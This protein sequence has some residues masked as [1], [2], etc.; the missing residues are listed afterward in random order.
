METYHSS[1]Q[2]MAMRLISWESACVTGSNAGGYTVSSVSYWAG[3]PTS[4]SVDLGVYADSS[5]TPGA[6]LCHASTGTITPTAGW[7]SVNISGCPTLSAGTRYWM[8]YIT[9][10]NQIQQ[11]TTPG[12]CPGTALSNVWANA[13]P[14]SAALSSPFGASSPSTNWCYSLY[15]TLNPVAVS[16]ACGETTQS[17]LDWQ[18]ARLGVATPCVTGT[19][20]GGYTVS[21]LSYCRPVRLPLTSFDLGVYSD[22]SGSPGSL[23]CH[24]STGTITPAAGWNSISISSC[25]TLSAST[26]YWV[27][28]VDGSDQI[29]QGTV[30]GTCTGTSN[31]TVFSNGVLP[32]VSLAN[33]FG[34]DSA[35]S[36][37]YSLYMTL[38]TGNQSSP[39]L[40]VSSSVNP[41]SYGQPVSLTATISSGPTGLVTFYSDGTQIGQALI[42]GTTATL[43]TTGLPLGSHSITA[44]WPGNANYQSVS[45]SPI[46][47][48]INVDTP[49][50]TWPTPAPLAYGLPLSATQLNATAN[51]PG[52]FVYTPAS[53]TVLSPGSHTLSVT[54][55]PTDTTDYTTA[56]DTVTLNVP[57]AP[58]AGIITTVAGDGGYGSSGDGGLAV[59][60]EL[61]SPEQIA[62][63]TTGNIKLP[64]SYVGVVRKVVASTGIIT[65]IAGTG[66][67]GYSGDGGQATSAQ[68]NTPMAIALDAAGNVYV[69]DSQS[70]RIRKITVSTGVITTIAGTG[71]AGYS[72]D[73]G[74]STSAQINYPLGVTFD[75]AGNL[76]IADTQNN[77][78]REVAASTGI[79]TTVAGNS[80][81]G[82]SGDGGP[83]TSA[84]LWG[85][86]SIAFDSSGN[87]YIADSYNQVIREVNHSSG[88][89]STIAGNRTAG[90]TGDNGPATSAELNYP[91][92]IS[93]DATGNV[94]ISDYANFVIRMVSPTGIITTV[95][96][97]GTSGFSGDGGPATS[98]QLSYPHGVALDSAGNLYIGDCG[99]HRVRVIGGASQAQVSVSIVPASATLYA[100][101]TKQFTATVT[102]TNNTAVTW[103]ITPAGSGSINSSGL[104]TA[105][106]TITTQQSVAVTATSQ[107][108][109]AVSSSA[110]VTLM[111]TI[112]VSISPSA[113]TL[114]W[115][116]IAAVLRNGNEHQQH[117]CDL[118]D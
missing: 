34:A 112:A 27:G 42:S 78:V 106:A 53:G 99:N 26:Q 90:Y 101:Q 114:L 9:G 38:S 60:A 97:N 59:N 16:N 32:G 2:M 62:V 66:T 103:S 115:R 75:S 8:G 79:I 76:Y 108:N 110:T 47:Q 96:G 55:T 68:L 69:A 83:A 37:C 28:Y 23:L 111:P 98:A 87:L 74:P 5:G 100:Q 91:Y 54:F 73:G 70:N 116:T 25:P 36:S 40:T 71:T 105:P 15:M 19:N 57:I 94:Y 41:A 86:E 10:S 33:P 80:F 92:A 13:S 113:A 12:V 6:L 29:Q 44:S 72:G 118:V 82:Y 93:V 18:N 51:A 85:P 88:T 46:T 107:A 20:V 1:I 117:C 30:S 22:S 104:Y 14:S 65:T 49:A 43:T 77:V 7:N 21:S 102:N 84:Q 109:T 61:E 56:T 64:D 11:G 63:E 95:A 45:S 67:E 48:T 17:G 4:T 35:T 31:Y 52:A 39:T 81:S 24:A 58:P 89:I 50:I 3:S